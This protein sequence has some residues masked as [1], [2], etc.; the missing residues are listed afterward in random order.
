MDAATSDGAT[1]LHVGNTLGFG[2][3]QT[4]TIGSGADTETAVVNSS[5]RGNRTI[6]LKAPLTHAHAAGAEVLGTGITLT[7]PLKL[8]HSREAQVTGSISTPGGPNHYFKKRP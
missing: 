4:I 6:A 8:A 5:R 1:V 2:G 3:G 7:A